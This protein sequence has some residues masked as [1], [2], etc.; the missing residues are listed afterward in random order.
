[1]NTEQSP[2]NPFWSRLGAIEIWNRQLFSFGFATVVMSSFAFDVTRLNNYS[3]LWIPATLLAF[4]VACAFVYLALEAYRKFSQ[5]SKSSPLFNLLLG[6]LAMGMESV[7]GITFAKLLGLTYLE[8]LINRFLQGVIIGIALLL[9]F[10]DLAGPLIQRKM[11]A[12]AKLPVEKG[13]LQHEVP[14]I[15]VNLNDS[16][17]PLRTWSLTL[18]AWF[19]TSPI[20]LPEMNAADL[21]LATLVFLVMLFLI[22]LLVSPISPVSFRVA[23]LSSGLVGI[24]AATPSFWLIYQIPEHP[25]QMPSMTVL[26]ILAGWSTVA[27]SYSYLLNSAE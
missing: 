7:F 20:L 16:I 3:L 25:T 24:I 10:N 18:F 23:L 15:Q 12:T 21:S 6:G 2:S 14:K 22:K 17:L 13:T 11:S 8:P 4:A 9:I 1:M 27:S 26:F 19:I 5:E